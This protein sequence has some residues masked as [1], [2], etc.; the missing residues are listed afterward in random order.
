MDVLRSESWRCTV[1]QIVQWS[2]QRHSCI[3]FISWAEIQCIFF[4]Q[5]KHFQSLP[6]VTISAAVGEGDPKS[7]SFSGGTD[8]FSPN[9]YFSKGGRSGFVRQRFNK[10][11]SSFWRGWISAAVSWRKL[12]WEVLN[13]SPENTP[14]TNDLIIPVCH[15]A[16]TRNTTE[17]PRREQNKQ[18]L[19]FGHKLRSDR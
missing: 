5:L 19:A 18:S 2:F 7:R 6:F 8:R 16:A 3:N 12:V 15:K 11:T 10:D 14:R 9:L 13:Q 4:S 1:G 17:R